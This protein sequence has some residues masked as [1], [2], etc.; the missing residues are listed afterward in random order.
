M[1]NT[2]KTYDP[3]E[4]YKK[5]MDEA[6]AAGDY[7]SAA[8]Y[9][10]KRNEKITGEG[11]TQYQTT[12]RY[13]QYLPKNQG[14]YTPYDPTGSVA[15]AQQLLQ[16]AMGNKPGAYQGTWDAQMQDMIGQILSRKPFDY[17]VNSDALYQQYREQYMRQGALAME[18]TMGKAAALTGGYGNSYAQAVGQQAYQNYVGYLN[19]RIPELYDRAFARY[20]QEGQDMLDKYAL[21]VSGDDREYG[22]YQDALSRYFTELGMAQDRYTDER[23]WQYQLGMD[24]YAK[25]QAEQDRAYELALSMLQSGMMPSEAVL[26]ASGISREDAQNIYNKANTPVYSGGGGG[27]GGSD[28][29]KQSNGKTMTDSMW[30]ELDGLYQMGQ[31]S[32]NMEDFYR[33]KNQLAAQGYDVAAFDSYAGSSY[34]G[35]D[36]DGVEDPPQPPTEQDILA[37][38]YGPISEQRLDELIRQGE[39]E[40]YVKNGKIYLRRSGK[41]VGTGLP[42]GMTP[43]R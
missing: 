36:S 30:K 20:Q 16:Q 25:E 5:K 33:R 18:D 42:G 35:Y 38:G 23:N 6:A 39:V 37:L 24:Q 11:L 4:D 41:K 27:G 15:Q 17:D 34:K 3:N 14:S 10:Q 29:D 43:Y 19:D 8:R 21:M 40:E 28:K 26:S 12:N 31:K 13:A 22:R 9:E 1:G 7:E 32:G 2:Y